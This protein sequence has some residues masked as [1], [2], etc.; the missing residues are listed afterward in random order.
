MAGGIANAR[1]QTEIPKMKSPSEACSR[2]RSADIS[3]TTPLLWALL[4]RTSF[5]VRAPDLGVAAFK[6]HPVAL[7]FAA[8]G[9][10]LPS[11]L[12]ISESPFVDSD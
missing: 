4:L 12:P 2:S 9:P 3:V 1:T 5:A 6:V 7:G 8:P 11:E 10:A